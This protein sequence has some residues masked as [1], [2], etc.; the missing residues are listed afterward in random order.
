MDNVREKLKEDI[1]GLRKQMT[2]LE[3]RYKIYRAQ[4]KLLTPPERESVENVA[5]RCGVCYLFNC[6]CSDRSSAV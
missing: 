4:L 5:R 6:R 2:A 3:Q 1:A